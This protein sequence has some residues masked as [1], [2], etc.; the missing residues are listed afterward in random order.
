MI[1]MAP[2]KPAAIGAL[3]ACALLA[4]YF[5]VLTLVS[6]W[7]YTLSQ[8]AEYWYYLVPLGIGFGAQ[9][10]LYLHLKQLMVDHHARHVVAATGT[11]STAAMI[12]CCAHYLANIVPVLG[13]TGAVTLIAEYQVELF[14]VGLAFNVAGLVYIGH[15]VYIGRIAAFGRLP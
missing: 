10:G 12:S 8:F 3:A 4:V 14:W 1:T 9:V 15:K 11:T 5:S 13:V 7:S 2:V 6:G